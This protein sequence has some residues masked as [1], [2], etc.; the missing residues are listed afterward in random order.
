MSHKYRNDP[1][2]GTVKLSS[3]SLELSFGSVFQYFNTSVIQCS[4][5][6]SSVTG[7]LAASLALTALSQPLSLN[8]ASIS[9]GC[10]HSSPG[11]RRLCRR[12]CHRLWA[13]SRLG[14]AHAL[15]TV[16]IWQHAVC[17]LASAT[18][19]DF[20]LREFTMQT[21]TVNGSGPRSL[22]RTVNHADNFHYRSLNVT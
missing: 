9:L 17:W 12:L 4:V 14:S 15:D 2:S 16:S 8:G 20:T 6:R 22:Q 21:T 19:R 13:V 11:T 5:S 18:C 10:K 3:E 1:P 7:S